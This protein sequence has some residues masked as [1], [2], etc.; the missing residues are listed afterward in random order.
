MNEKEFDQQSAATSAAHAQSVRSASGAVTPEAGV[1][2]AE[3]NLEVARSQITIDI[4]QNDFIPV[5]DVLDALARI[6]GIDVSRKTLIGVE[7]VKDRLDIRN[8]VASCHS[9]GSYVRNALE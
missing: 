6:K 9:A 4:P 3:Q 2:P 8:A 5:A 1:Q 7:L